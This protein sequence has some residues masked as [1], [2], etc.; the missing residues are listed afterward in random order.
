MRH[1][2]GALVPE[3]TKSFAQQ[4]LHNVN[5]AEVVHCSKLCP[6]F[7]DLD[8]QTQKNRKMENKNEV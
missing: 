3:N 1:P 4:K 8:A 5:V 7:E 2:P 6:F